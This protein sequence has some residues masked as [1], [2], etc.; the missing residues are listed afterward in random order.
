MH[1]VPDVIGQTTLGSVEREEQKPEA[2]E[3][4][5]RPGLVPAGTVQHQQQPLSVLKAS[6]SRR[7]S[8]MLAVLHLVQVSQANRP[9]LGSTAAKGTTCFGTKVRTERGRQ[10]SPARQEQHVGAR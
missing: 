2:F 7:N 1:L 10:Q 3:Q 8:D 9:R 4:R 5:K 6:S